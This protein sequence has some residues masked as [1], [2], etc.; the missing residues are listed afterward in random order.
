[1]KTILFGFI[2]LSVFM[3]SCGPKSTGDQNRYELKGK[4]VSVEVDKNQVTVAHEEVK[5]FM[6]AMTMPFTL[7]DQESLKFLQAGD[8]ISAILVVEGAES[9]LEQPVITRQSEIPGATSVGVSPAKHGDE[10]PD[11]AMVNQDGKDIRIHGYRGKVLLLT[12]IYTRCP[13]PEYCDLMS[14]NFAKVDRQLQQQ[15]DIYSKTHLLSISID[16]EYDTPKVLK[17]YGAAHTERYQEETF[18]HWEFATGSKDQIKSVAQFFGLRYFQSTDQIQ[19][20]LATVMIGADG[21]VV[22]VWDDNK[23]SPDEVAAEMAKSAK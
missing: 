8:Q 15:P 3:F 11:F 7:R 5:D 12:F 21:K 16:P 17:S 18:K 10:V 9:W 14:N 13:L 4:V 1:M 23:W 20:N 2:T 6:P 19:H 22:R